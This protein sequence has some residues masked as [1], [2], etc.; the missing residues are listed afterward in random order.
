MVYVCLGMRSEPS[1]K[2]P[3]A[4]K[5]RT[6]RE[7]MKKSRRS[8]LRLHEI[9]LPCGPGGRLAA[10]D[11]ALR[12]IACVTLDSDARVR[13]PQALNLLQPGERIFCGKFPNALHSVG[14]KFMVLILEFT[15]EIVRFDSNPLEIEID[16]WNGGWDGEDGGEWNC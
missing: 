10:S 6:D 7:G 16:E 12:V 8:S 11:T 1:R 14:A 9:V 13:M 4:A 3:A 15:I 5:K 2:G